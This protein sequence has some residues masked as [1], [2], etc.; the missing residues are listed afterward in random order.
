[1][2]GG[3]KRVRIPRVLAPEE[4]QRL[5]YQLKQPYRTMVLIASALGLRVSEIVAL[6]WGRLML[7][8]LDAH[9]NPRLRPRASG[10][11]KN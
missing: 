8:T 9:G 1:M 10:R 11:R 5:I 3:T 2:R 7:G 6:Q 4:V